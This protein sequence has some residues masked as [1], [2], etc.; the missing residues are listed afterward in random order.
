MIRLIFQHP[1]DERL[2]IKVMREERFS[3]GRYVQS[4]PWLRIRRR[5]GVYRTYTR[6]ISEY[7][8]LR[9]RFRGEPIPVEHLLGVADTDLGLGLVVEKIVGR[10]GRPA[11]TLRHI[12]L[13]EGYSQE[14]EDR[15]I[16]L[17]DE[18][19]EK[20]IITGDLHDSNIVA[21]YSESRG[22][23]LVIVDG[24]GDKTLIPINSYS[25]IINRNSNMRHFRRVM[26]GM[27]QVDR[28]RNQGRLSSILK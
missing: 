3:P 12:V 14:L 2:L 10:D 27:R 19:I 25:R 28:L 7:L 24:I 16:Q 9:A 22:D 20:D 17:R 13:T 1:H 8:E 18:V 5:Y 21:G 15:V 6:Q 23:S 11:P 4:V 26:E